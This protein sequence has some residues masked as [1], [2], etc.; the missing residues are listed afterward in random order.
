MPHETFEFRIGFRK[1]LIGVFLTVVPISLVAIYAVSESAS[2]QEAQVGYH[3][4]TIAEST[5]TQVAQF[6]HG[7]VIEAGLM[8]AN[9]AVIDVVT[10]ANRSYQGMSESAIGAR[11][12]QREDI[13]TTP[14]ADRLVKEILSSRASRVLRRYLQIDPTFLRITV[15]DEKGTTTA[16][17]HKT[18]D[19]FQADE[20]FWQNIYAQGR[21]AISLTDIEYDV[22]T[23]ANYI[24]VG[25]PIVDEESGGLIGTLDALVEVSSLFPIVR[26]ATL[27]ATGRALLVKDDG[28]V[29]SGPQ[30]T[31]SM[32]LKSDEYAAVLDALQTLR[33]RA[34]GYVVADFGG[35]RGEA[36]IGYA[37]TGLKEDFQNLSWVVL[38][39][40]PGDEAF[41][42]IVTAQRLIMII[43]FLGIAAAVML[44]VYFSLHRRAEME[45]LE[46]E[47]HTPRDNRS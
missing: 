30:T 8:A 15:T 12:K 10:A 24:G 17:T 21:G 46:E 7:R 9:P 33:G 16:A 3:F 36:V 34:T 38:V 41:A 29:I 26:R 39:S 40:Q 11:I 14:A 13:W 47:F 22:V 1:L 32:N 28:T 6:I 5:A 20:E 23:K 27:G 2:S 42:P 37:D 19:Y 4:K 18:I 44:A 35:D 43:A 45:E 25:V 31:L